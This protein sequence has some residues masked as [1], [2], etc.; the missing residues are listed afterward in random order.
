MSHVN[1]QLVHLELGKKGNNLFWIKK[2]WKIELSVSSFEMA[3]PAEKQL[4]RIKPDW[5]HYLT[6]NY[7]FWLCTEILKN[8]N[9]PYSS[10]A[11]GDSDSD[12]FWWTSKNPEILWLYVFV[13]MRNTLCMY[14]YTMFTPGDTFQLHTSIHQS[15]LVWRARSI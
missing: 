6:L 4:R 14:V 3:P 1:H 15:T 8:F 9:T 11:R 5:L 2:P 12:S 10:V 13:C 7:T